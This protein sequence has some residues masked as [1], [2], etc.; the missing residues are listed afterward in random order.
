MD[1]IVG[2]IE[3]LRRRRKIIRDDLVGQKNQEIQTQQEK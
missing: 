1:L 3:L 2:E